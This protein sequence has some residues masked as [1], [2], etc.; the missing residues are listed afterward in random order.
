M[1]I[2]LGTLGIAIGD[3]SANFGSQHIGGCHFAFCDGSV[4]FI[5]Q[6]IDINTYQR[7]GNRADGQIVGDF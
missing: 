4:R 7:L 6:N 2:N 3:T 5:S 1:N